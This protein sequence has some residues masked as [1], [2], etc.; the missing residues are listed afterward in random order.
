MYFYVLLAIVLL[1]FAYY[2]HSI[3][4]S[5]RNMP[6]GPFVVP[7][8]GSVPAIWVKRPIIK[9]NEARPWEY[10]DMLSKTYGDLFSA[11]VLGFDAGNIFMSLS[12]F[13][14]PNGSLH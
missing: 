12:E 7:I 9:L 4:A 13:H 8:L 14:T 5:T 1:L 3:Q 6:P 11:T 2:L 10:L